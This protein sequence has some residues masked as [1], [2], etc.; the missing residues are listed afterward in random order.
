M[1][2]KVSRNDSLVRELF[3]IAPQAIIK[4]KYRSELGRDIFPTAQS[5]FPDHLPQSNL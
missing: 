2:N 3:I 5:R 1:Q 4:G